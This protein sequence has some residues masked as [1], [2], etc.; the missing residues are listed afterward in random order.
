MA[1]FVTKI[2]GKYP[3]IISVPHGG[4]LSPK[5]IPDR[6]KGVMGLDRRTRFVAK[7]LKMALAKSG[8]DPYLVILNVSRNKIDVNRSKAEGCESET[9]CQIWDVYHNSLQ[10]YIDECRKKY[11]KCFLIDLHG[12]NHN[13]KIELG[14]CLKEDQLLNLLEK[15]ILV[16]CS[17]EHSQN[18]S[19]ETDLVL[20]NKSFGYFLE[21]Q[22][23]T[24]MPSVK[25]MPNKD[26]K[27][28]SGAYTTKHYDFESHVR[29]FQLELNYENLRDSYLG[30]RKFSK[31]FSK[32]LSEYFK[33][34]NF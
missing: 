33:E 10:D 1:E 15:H 27:Y 3:L 24:A 17:V 34:I 26:E 19:D 32:A 6:K 29:G 30:I 25:E 20:G 12:Q 22:G 11:G 21:R 7:S 5:N 14:Y 13:K 18:L 28:F 2:T 23:Y 16:K 8:L 31:A 4:N 9:A